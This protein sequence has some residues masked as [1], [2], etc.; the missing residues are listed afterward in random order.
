M[1]KLRVGIIGL[2]RVGT[3]LAEELSKTPQDYAIYPFNRS[4]DKVLSLPYE[5]T[6]PDSAVIK[7]SL[8]DILAET[9]VAV[10]TTS[11]FEKRGGEINRSSFIKQ[12]HPIM[13]ELGNR[14]KG[15]RGKV[16][17]VT[18]P[19]DEC[20]FH[21][22]NASGLGNEQIVGLNH[23][24]SIRYK[25]LIRKIFLQ[26]G[27]DIHLD[28][29]QG[30]HTLGPHNE[31]VFPVA[32]KLNIHGQD[33]GIVVERIR[34]I[35]KKIAKYAE[36][37]LGGRTS[38]TWTTVEAICDVLKATIIPNK[39]ISVSTYYKG[40][41][42]GLPV[43]FVGQNI[44]LVIDPIGELGDEE[45]R[46]FRE[47]YVNILSALTEQ[48]VPQA[49]LKQGQITLQAIDLLLSKGQPKEP[50]KISIIDKLNPKRRIED[51]PYCP[52]V[53]TKKL[54]SGAHGSVYLAKDVRDNSIVAIKKSPVKEDI[55]DEKEILQ[56]LSHQ[57]II[58][59]IDY[60]ENE[61]EGFLV[62]EYAEKDITFLNE[63]IL[64]TKLAAIL[65]LFEGLH[66]IHSNGIVH[67][68]IKPENILLTDN[69]LLK[70][71]DFALSQDM[72]NTQA[73]DTAKWAINYASPELLCGKISPAADI[74]SAGAI[75]FE[76]LT[77]ISYRKRAYEKMHTHD[78]LSLCGFGTIISRCLERDTANRY[79]SAKEV[80]SDLCSKVGDKG[81]NFTR[82]KPEAIASGWLTITGE[83][84]Q[85]KRYLKKLD[86]VGLASRY[87]SKNNAMAALEVYRAI[88]AL[89]PKDELAESRIEEIHK[90]VAG[91]I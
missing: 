89:Y 82:D 53:F 11:G 12:N 9:D 42:I 91:M 10:I 7:D 5:L 80:L 4:R 36:T 18:N 6:Y 61:E 63:E 71:A 30:C 1:H 68:D 8:E 58:K 48:E 37:Q 74:Y 40:L 16:I 27:K 14:F 72:N 81:I 3:T 69:G 65:Q 26:Q 23:T 15:Y 84:T 60:F 41:F 32:S 64:G 39:A 54:G 28:E 33:T 29:I 67:L 76:L 34:D 2:G 90:K 31:L 86:L 13:T 87:E 55:K 56:R 35:Q 24:D 88:L 83:I 21:F 49:Y 19:V 25:R 79:S 78:S 66:Y 51:M 73:I 47:G 45:L 38:T 59:F 44:K 85:T 57:Q 43:Q 52:Y 17:I 46:Y 22:W 20:A 77:G 50:E 75:A 70:L 62:T